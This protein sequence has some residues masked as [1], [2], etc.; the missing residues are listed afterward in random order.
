LTLYSWP[1]NIRQLQNGLE[2]ALIYANG[3]PLAPKHF[4]DV[5]SPKDAPPRFLGEEAAEE[6]ADVQ[7]VA[8]WN[9]GDIERVH[10]LRALERFGGDKMKASEA[11]GISLSTLYRKLDKFWSNE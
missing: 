2:R 5:V 6:E 8:G 11:L 7:A 4:T 10:I 9:L 1:G 3:G